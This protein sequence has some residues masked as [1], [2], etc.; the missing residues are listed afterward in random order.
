MVSDGNFVVTLWFNGDLV[1]LMDF[2]DVHTW[3]DAAFQFVCKEQG[4]IDVYHY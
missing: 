4:S 1:D 3:S 2:C